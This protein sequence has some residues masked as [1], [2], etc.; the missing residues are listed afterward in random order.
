MTSLWRAG[1]EYSQKNYPNSPPKPD[2]KLPERGRAALSCCM[3]VT[4]SHAAAP[5]KMPLEFHGVMV[6]QFRNVFP[7]I[8]DRFRLCYLEFVLL[9]CRMTSP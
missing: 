8:W 6:S 5:W 7:E 3:G 4:V 2:L 9:L 1:V